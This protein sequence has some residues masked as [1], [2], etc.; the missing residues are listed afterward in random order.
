MKKSYAIGIVVAIAVIVGVSISMNDSTFETSV[1]I[2]E[3]ETSV[4]IIEEETGKKHYSI[5][6]K[7]TVQVKSH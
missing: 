1:N 2:I 5:S 6:L 4:K 3:E 7:E